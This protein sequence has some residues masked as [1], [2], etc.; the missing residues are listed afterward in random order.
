MKLGPRTK[1]THT[2]ICQ[3]CDMSSLNPQAPKEK[4]HGKLKNFY[5]SMSRKLTD[6][7]HLPFPVY[8]R[9]LRAW[10]VTQERGVFA[11]VDEGETVLAGTEVGFLFISKIFI[12][13]NEDTGSGHQTG[14]ISCSKKIYSQLST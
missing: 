3:T 9:C 6:V 10:R 12:K 13:L 8:C 7:Y 5:T 4:Y 14:H 11:K 2:H 1:N